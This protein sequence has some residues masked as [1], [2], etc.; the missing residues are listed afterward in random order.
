V[1]RTGMES[2]LVVVEGAEG[3]RTRHT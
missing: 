2:P 3:F 1:R